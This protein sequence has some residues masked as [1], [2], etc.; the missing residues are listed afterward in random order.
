MSEMER[1][2]SRRQFVV[3]ASSVA[4]LAP[5]RLQGARGSTLRAGAHA[6][7]IT[8]QKFPVFC[9]GGFLARTAT[10]SY[11]P[12]HARCL[13]LDD[14]ATRLAIVVVDNCVMPR[15]LLDTAKEMASKAAGIPVERM[16]ISATH[17]HSA[18]A[19]RLSLGCPIAK[20]YAAYLPGRIAKGIELAAS[21][22]A[23]AKAGWAVVDDFEHTHCRRWIYRPDRMGMDPFGGRTVRAMMHPG[24]QNPSCVGPSGPVD[25]ALSMLAVQSLDG[26]PLALLANY[27]QHYRGAPMLSAD[28][29]GAFCREFAKLVGA[30]K[31]D[32]PFVAMLSQGTSGDLQFMDYSKPRK[33]GGNYHTYGAALARL[34]AGAC[35]TIQYRERVPLAM[36]EARL[37]LR[38]RT[39]DAGRTAWAKKIVAGMKGPMPRSRV[40]VYA[41][42]QLLLTKQPLAELR[43]QAIRIGDLGITAI[44]CEVYGVTGLKLKA[45]SPLQPTFNMSQANGGEG[46][47]PPPAQHAL[48]GYSTWPTV[49][50]GLEVEAE[51]KI[52]ET[53]L[54]LLEKVAQK[55]RRKPITPQG[56]YA[57]AVLAS[58]PLAYWR[59]DEFDGPR[60]TDA[61]GNGQHG[62]YEDGVAFYLPGP[63]GAALAGQGQTGRAAHFAGGRMAASVKELGDAYSIELW[64][65][66]GLPTNARP[67]TGYL[68]SR[69][70]N[71]DKSCPGDHLGIAGSYREPGKLFF[72]NGD[73]LRESVRGSTS[74]PLRTWNHVV[75]VRDGKR[76]CVT[77]NGNPTAEIASE[78]TVTRPQGVQPVFVGG[79]C[80]RFATFEGRICD[81]AVYGRALTAAEAAAHYRAAGAR[82][83]V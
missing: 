37:T 41:R 26:R 11:D 44:P 2:V 52:T 83:T 8:P 56:A 1:A 3:A 28:Y 36:A 70:P 23:P 47:I 31:Q 43:L 74:I 18:P 42:N 64:F 20:E 60:A 45:H 32:P 21:T 4:A 69:G 72:F 15:G 51:P 48:G 35:K 30:E 54:G 66:N 78:A 63:E 10:K 50:A 59:M 79:R 17:T 53:V 82:P 62:A 71:G 73:T 67:V 55:P 9:N 49:N 29:Y 7:D 76:V 14:G 39:P 81:A 34:A 38:R 19:L 61:S 12:L 13:V 6:I 25:P 77:L 58:K 68:F 22:L 80:D 75:L 46:Y 40:E 5:A 16:L 57:K 65:W 27:S 24:H 33:P